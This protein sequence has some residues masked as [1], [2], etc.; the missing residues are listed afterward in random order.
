MK[1]WFVS[2][3]HLKDINERNSIELLRFLHFIY[4]DINTT[5]LFLLGDIFDLWVGDSKVFY[6]KF[7]AIVDLIDKIKKSGRE[8]VYF[9]GNHDVHIEK[10][11][12]S[13]LQIPVHI[14]SEM[15]SLGP[16][17]VQLEHG[18]YINPEDLAY[19]QYLSVLRSQPMKKI[20]HTLPGFIIDGI[21]RWASRTSRKKSQLYRKDSE[22]LLRERIRKFAHS[23]AQKNKFDF[24]ITGHMHVRDDYT[25]NH[26][27]RSIRS[28]NLGSWFEEPKTF[29]LTDTEACWFKISELR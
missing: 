27:G 20:A 15:F 25:F 2:D 1:A 17:Q 3:I 11:W 24:I 14:E 10:F 19:I 6:R 29:C 9:E 28:I 16:F 4:D 21:G 23:Q 13:H 12:Q 8:V 5:H 22:A 18:D 7:K 26:E